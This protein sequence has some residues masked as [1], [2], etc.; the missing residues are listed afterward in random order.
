MFTTSTSNLLRGL[1][2]FA[3]ILFLSACQTNKKLTEPPAQNWSSDVEL[4]DDKRVLFDGFS[5][6]KLNAKVGLKVEGKNESASMVW[7]KSGT[8]DSVRLFGPLG[9]KAV[10]LE[11]SEKGAL[12]TDDK[13]IEYRGLTA[14]SL[15]ED[16]TG[17]PIP[18]DYMQS[19][20]LGLPDLDA[21]A[22][23]TLNETR[24]HELH[25]G[26]WYVVYSYRPNE[27][28]AEFELPRRLVA[29][30]KLMGRDVEL[31]IIVKSW[32]RH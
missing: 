32:N 30:S 24:L 31:K 20:I 10:K 22:S 17:W 9:A 16:V 4:F 14:N 13:G 15:L 5:N 27:K 2:I 29:Q 26:G 25:Q 8:Q 6:W 11:L 18:V 19:W 12:L 3:V 1:A 7:L 28:S 21:P 23:F